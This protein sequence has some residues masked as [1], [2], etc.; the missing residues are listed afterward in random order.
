MNNKLN[1]TLEQWKEKMALQQAQAVKRAE[2]KQPANRKSGAASK[3]GSGRNSKAPAAASDTTIPPGRRNRAEQKAG[4]TSK[5]DVV[6]NKD[7]Y[8]V[9]SNNPKIRMNP[10]GR[11][12]YKPAHELQNV[13]EVLTLVSKHPHGVM[14]G[15]IKDA[16]K[17]VGEDVKARF[18]HLTYCSA[19]CRRKLKEEGKVWCIHNAIEKDDVL[20]PKDAKPLITLSQDLVDFWH[21]TRVPEDPSQ[22][23]EEL[24]KAKLPAAPR[25]VARKRVVLPPKESK[26]RRRAVNM[27]TATNQHMPELFA[28]AMPVQID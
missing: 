17:G 8:D 25:K 16:Y 15:Q 27:L 2:K 14:A 11:Y 22:L 13:D 20:F 26:K 5:H 28:G 23:I 9:L 1:T 7:L 4:E 12:V 18:V 10:D 3:A 24:H 19:L 21:A 6:G